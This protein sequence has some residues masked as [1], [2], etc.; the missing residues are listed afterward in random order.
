MNEEN[1]WE[2]GVT[3]R[4]QT[5]AQVHE[6]MMVVDLTGRT[7]GTVELVR[8]GD[9]DAVTT[10]G[11]EPVPAEVVE[12]VGAAVFG[13]EPEVP[14]P[15]RSQLIRLGFIKIDGPGLSDTDCYVRSDHISAV[16]GER[17]VLAVSKEQLL[18]EQ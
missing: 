3:R 5:I 7:L 15:K 10:H 13:H 6:G 18:V 16:S 17:I 4:E 11:N 9:P 12:A 14:E 1:T 8:M 2:A